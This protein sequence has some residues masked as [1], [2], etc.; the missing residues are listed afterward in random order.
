MCDIWKEFPKKDICL[1]SIKEVLSSKSMSKKPDFALTGGEPFMNKNLFG[2][3]KQILNVYPF[4]LKTISTN[5]TSTERILKF[6]STFRKELPEDFSLHISYDGPNH[7]DLQRG[8]RSKEKI[9]NTI[10]TIKK[11]FKHINLKIKFT[12]TPTNYKDIIPT[13]DF[14]IKNRLDFRVK[15]VENAKNYTNKI[16]EKKITFKN[17][18]KKSI[19]KDLLKVYKRKSKYDKRNAEFIK[20]SINLLLNKSTKKDCYVPFEKIFMMPNGNIYTCIHSESIG[21]INKK[22]LDNIWKSE[23]AQS[24][25]KEVLNHGCKDCVSYHGSCD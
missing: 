25:R 24:I 18:I 8:Y 20:R 16:D 15:L 12:I 22:S 3:T 17:S 1:D 14:C 7:H 2:I 4:S 10:K 19:I 5:G 23:K 11:D 21:N 9:L 6:L 13:Y